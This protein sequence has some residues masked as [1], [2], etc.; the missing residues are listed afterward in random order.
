MADPTVDLDAMLDE[1][2]TRKVPT[3]AG[4]SVQMEGEGEARGIQEA[5]EST[6]DDIEQMRQRIWNTWGCI[7]TREYCQALVNFIKEMIDG[8]ENS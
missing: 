1:I 7:T 5:L 8:K 6:L 4:A 2:R 3:V